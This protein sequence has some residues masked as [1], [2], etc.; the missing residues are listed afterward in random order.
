MSI[1]RKDFANRPEHKERA[2]TCVEYGEYTNHGKR[3]SDIGNDICGGSVRHS[4]GI[5][6][7][8]IHRRNARSNI[9]GLLGERIDLVR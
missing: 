8:G 9:G 5:I 4:N 7:E 2:N 3:N 1:L 6:L